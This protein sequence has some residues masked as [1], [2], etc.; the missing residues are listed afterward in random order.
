MQKQKRSIFLIVGSLAIGLALF[1]FAANKRSE[2]QTLQSQLGPTADSA[3]TRSKYV[4][5]S[6][7]QS[8]LGWALNQ[9]GDRLERPGKERAAISG[10][11]RYWNEPTTHSLALLNEFPDRLRANLTIGSDLRTIVFDGNRSGAASQES[12]ADEALLETLVYD[13]AEH[14]FWSQTRQQATRFIGSR[15]RADDG[16]TSDYT[17]PYHDVYQL[18]DVVNIGSTQQV[19]SKFYYFNS[20]T[21]LL[22]QVLYQSTNQ[23]GTTSVEVRLNDW[24]R[25]NH[26]RLPH[27][28]ER[29]ENGISRFVFTV[30]SSNL[31]PRLDDGAF[32]QTT[33]N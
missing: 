16:S 10:S 29:I 30:S 6:S 8:R 20:D 4:R 19:R 11:V 21:L 23:N 25:I 13:S 32:D 17:G 27:R 9:L 14:F 12:E 31:G 28:I 18:T 15:I 5:R 1:V 2:S 22:E 3:T 24:R 33:S 26:Q 7:L